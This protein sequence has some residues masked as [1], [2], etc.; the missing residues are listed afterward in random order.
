MSISQAQTPF[1]G[2]WSRPPNQ[3]LLGESRTKIQLNV[4]FTCMCWLRLSLTAYKLDFGMG[5]IVT[6]KMIPDFYCRKCAESEINLNYEALSCTNLNEKLLKMV[7]ILI[8]LTLQ[9]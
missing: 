1:S 4:R 8:Q 6:S 2:C 3:N 9:K 5:T 7:V